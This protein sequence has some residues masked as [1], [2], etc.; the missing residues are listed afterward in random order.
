MKFCTLVLAGMISLTVLAPVSAEENRPTFRR[1]IG[2][3]SLMNWGALRPGSRDRYTTA[4]FADSDHAVPEALL[5]AVADAG[6][7]FVRL[8]LDP[9]PFL[10][11]TGPARDGLDAHL[12]SVIR[13]LAGLGL[14]VVVDLHGNTQVPTYDPQAIVA[15][16]EAPLFLAYVD[17]VRRTAKVLAGIKDARL[18]FELMNEPPYGYDPESRRRWQGMIERLHA[19]AR[20]E[21]PNLTLIL[22][23]AHGGDR[24]GLQA[25][26]P[27]PFRDSRVLYSFHYY[28]PHDFTHQGVPASGGLGR[29]R[30][31][32][33]DLPYPS[34]SLPP[35]LVEKT[36]RANVDGDSA[37]DPISRVLIR[38][39][40]LAKVAAYLKRG[41][42]RTS[43]GR[44]FETV[45]DWAR[46]HGIP[47]E[48][49][50]LGEFGATRTYDDHRAADP[51]SYEAWLRDVRLE[52]EARGFG[53]AV[54]A[55]T[56]TGG[57]ALV[58]TDGGTRLDTYS[59][60][61]LGLKRQEGAD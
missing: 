27:T 33:S 14:S 31:F 7:D 26:D 22:T 19:V 11:L 16:A 15:S 55:L 4:P 57:M 44:D 6:F 60:Q 5:R 28:E 23:G 36:V 8:T 39:E 50:F 20:A 61:A 13:R 2:V 47:G 52:A 29:Y 30:Q 37:L 10:Q 59:L 25:L 18:A 12:A 53:W 42:N 41:S 9:G 35:A 58:A 46:R 24:E 38:R 43:I 17:L 49:I 51:L 3:H 56:G 1:G 21:A 48:R 40:A 54:W 45:S 32:L 34:D